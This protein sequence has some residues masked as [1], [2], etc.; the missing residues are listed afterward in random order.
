M[1]KRLWELNKRRG[2][3][4]KELLLPKE[5]IYGVFYEK[6]NK[7]GNSICQCHKGGERHGP[8]HYLNFRYKG[9]Q[10]MVLVKKEDLEKVNMRA[11]NYR[12]YQKKLAEI[13]KIN[14]EIFKIL[15]VIRGTKVKYYGVGGGR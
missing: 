12:E 7:C 5:M 14:E 6:T 3:L 15:K 11:R 8:Y 10:K 13:R 4:Q 2:I 1:R 9:K